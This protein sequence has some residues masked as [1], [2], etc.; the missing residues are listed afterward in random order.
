MR[1]HPSRG[2]ERGSIGDFGWTGVPGNSGEVHTLPEPVE[3]FALAGRSLSRPGILVY[4][5]FRPHRLGND[6]RK[7]GKCGRGRVEYVGSP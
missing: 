6:G 3:E 5:A 4:G 7:L 1:P 2:G